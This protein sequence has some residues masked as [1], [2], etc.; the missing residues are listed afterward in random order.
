MATPGLDEQPDKV[1]A[2]CRGDQNNAFHP[3]V[4]SRP[5]NVEI[6]KNLQRPAKP[7]MK[8]TDILSPE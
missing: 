6:I 3:T 1:Y 7:D 5:E 2:T 4:P 8:Q